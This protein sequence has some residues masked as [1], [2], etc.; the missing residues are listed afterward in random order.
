[1]TSMER[2]QTYL[3]KQLRKAIESSGLS[4]YRISKKSG[5]S[6][7]VL[8]RFL[9]GQRGMTL[10]TASRLAESLGLELAA[11]KRKAARRTR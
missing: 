8:S 9:N 11:K 5:V 4:V 6:E 7:G 3:E 1:M 10:A 2:K